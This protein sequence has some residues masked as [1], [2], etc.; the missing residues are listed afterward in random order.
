M[1]KHDFSHS[2]TQLTPVFVTIILVGS[3]LAVW[4][5]MNFFTCFSTR[6]HQ[7]CTD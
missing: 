3:V 7:K 1:F 6:N 4:L 2:D 5:T